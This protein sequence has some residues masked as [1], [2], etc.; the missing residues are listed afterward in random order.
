MNSEHDNVLTAAARVAA[1]C[2]HTRMAL[3]RDKKTRSHL[4]IHTRGMSKTQQETYN[5]P[6][7][8]SNFT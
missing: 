5:K 8:L 6:Q 7:S 3:R 1:S 2:T 4:F